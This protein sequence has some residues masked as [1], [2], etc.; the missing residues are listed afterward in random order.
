MWHSTIILTMDRH[1]HPFH[2]DEAATL[3]KLPG[4]SEG[5][6]NTQPLRATGT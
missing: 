3:E 5:G 4:F 2:S 1:A 6:Q